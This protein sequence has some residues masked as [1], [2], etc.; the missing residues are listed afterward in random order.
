MS[1]V[2]KDKAGTWNGQ[3][4]QYLTGEPTDLVNGAEQITRRPDRGPITENSP[5]VLGHL[6]ALHN[7]SGILINTNDLSIEF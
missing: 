6:N 7:L 2:G 4:A 1:A 3:Y 5:Q